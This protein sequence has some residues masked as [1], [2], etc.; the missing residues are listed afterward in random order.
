MPRLKGRLRR[1]IRPTRK[2]I[3]RADIRELTR[4]EK[5]AEYYEER[6]ARKKIALSQRK[7]IAE[8]KRIIHPPPKQLKALKIQPS[9]IRQIGSGGK[10]IFSSLVQAGTNVNQNLQRD[11]GKKRKRR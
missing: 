5:E 8:A 1:Y 4:L 10:F 6:A 3:K 2:E 11:L 9:T 7:R